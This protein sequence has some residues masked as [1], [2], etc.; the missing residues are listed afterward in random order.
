VS[1]PIIIGGE[2]QV[3]ISRDTLTNAAADAR[4]VMTES[5][6]IPQL[7]AVDIFTRQLFLLVRDALDRELKHGWEITNPE[8]VLQALGMSAQEHSV[9]TRATPKQLREDVLNTILPVLDIFCTMQEETE[10]AALQP[11]ST[12]DQQVPV[13]TSGDDNQTSGELAEPI[14][15][16]CGDAV[17][18]AGKPS[19]GDSP[20]GGGTVS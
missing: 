20:E 13:T 3:E 8:L 7:V 16:S 1:S 11:A 15:P 10:N 18:E 9:K 12:P 2:E 17:N 6:V 14:G 19:E 4:I 5:P